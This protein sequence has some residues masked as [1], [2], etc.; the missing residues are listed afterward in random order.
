ML[1][2][3]YMIMRDDDLSVTVR[4]KAWFRKWFPRRNELFEN[5]LSKMFSPDFHSTRRHF[6]TLSAKVFMGLIFDWLILILSRGLVSFAVHT[7]G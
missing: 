5:Y 3:L 6:E 2:V 7:K 4:R 1:L